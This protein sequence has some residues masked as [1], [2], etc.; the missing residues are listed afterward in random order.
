M[1]NLR[2]TQNNQ[3]QNIIIFIE[4]NDQSF[5]TSEKIA[6]LFMNRFCIDEDGG[7]E[8]LGVCDLSKSSDRIGCMK[9]KGMN[10]RK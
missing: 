8:L 10:M 7:F 2:N 1:T 4:P 9:H 5:I 6:N 3:M